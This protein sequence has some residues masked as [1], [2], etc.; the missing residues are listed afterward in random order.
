MEGVTHFFVEMEK[1]T[2]KIDL[3]SFASRGIPCLQPLYLNHCILE[4]DPDITQ[5]YI[6]EY[7]EIM[8]NM[9]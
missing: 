1:T 7:K 8:A 4:E 2:E 5:A 3:A 6:P 9:R